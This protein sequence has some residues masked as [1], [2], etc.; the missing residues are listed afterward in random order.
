MPIKPAGLADAR[1]REGGL[2]PAPLRARESGSPGGSSGGYRRR[3]FGVS[4]DA[5]LSVQD[6]PTP[7]LLPTRGRAGHRRVLTRC[8]LRQ[9]R[10]G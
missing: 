9:A 8:A 10:A 7:S 1:G 5:G 4:P 3:P 2:S 6:P